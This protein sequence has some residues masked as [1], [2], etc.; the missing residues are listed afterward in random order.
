MVIVKYKAELIKMN[1][2]CEKILNPHLIGRNFSILNVLEKPICQKKLLYR[3]SKR[4]MKETEEILGRFI[5]HQYKNFTDED[6][7][8]LEGFLDE[9]DPDIL[10][11]IIIEKALPD[12]YDKF[13]ILKSLKDYWCDFSNSQSE[14]NK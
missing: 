3:A 2:I 12:K 13:P 9:P 10:K 11:W 7:R 5:N 1:F 14:V 6:V 8:V 4:G